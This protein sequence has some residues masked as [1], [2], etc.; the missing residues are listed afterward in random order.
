[1]NTHVRE[2]FVAGTVV[3]HKE[4]A[5][6]LRSLFVAATVEPFIA[7][8]FTQLALDEE[9]RLLRP[10]SFVNAPSQKTL[11]FYYSLV[12]GGTF[13]TR[14][15]ALLPGDTIFVAKRALGRFTLS[16]V[17]NADRLWLFATGTGLGVF[18]SI[19]QTE[20]PWQRFQKIV[21]VHSVQRVDCLTHLDLIHRW[22]QQFPDQ[23]QWIP[24]VTGK[25][26][27]GAFSVR[28]TE[29]LANGQLEEKTQLQINTQSSQVMLCGNPAMIRDVC[30]ILL[31]R[32]LTLNH[33]STPGHITLENYWKLID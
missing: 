9:L 33:L 15:T 6:G 26:H 12:P 13:S 31:E 18:L 28:V 25:H 23:F 17:P 5:P 30:K 32:G 10:Y 22:Q 14:L 20:E 24:I 1:M 21:L 29:L 4:W 8:Q 11:E 7:G 16:G 19:L 2:R 27:P 3:A